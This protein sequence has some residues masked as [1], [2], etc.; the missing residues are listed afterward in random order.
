MENRFQNLKK[1]FKSSLM[2]IE[3]F[4][5]IL[6]MI[7]FFYEFQCSSY[8]FFMT[9]KYCYMD[10]GKNFKYSLFFSS[11]YEEYCILVK[12]RKIIFLNPEG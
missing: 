3:N 8:L 7:F 5:L 2:F 10:H 12:K 1:G 9:L 11:Y 4:P 6:E